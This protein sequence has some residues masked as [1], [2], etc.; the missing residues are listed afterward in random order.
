MLL[1]FFFSHLE[2][3]DNLLLFS[4]QPLPET[5]AVHI[6]RGLWCNRGC[7]RDSGALSLHG[8]GLEQL[9]WF[10]LY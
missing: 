2:E 8:K 10:C 4:V 9:I 5:R 6:N 1:L 7:F 3:R